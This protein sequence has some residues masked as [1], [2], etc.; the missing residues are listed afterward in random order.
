MHDIPYSALVNFDTGVIADAE[1]IT[2]RRLSDMPGYYRDRAAVER[3][4][5]DDPLLYRVYLTP[6][7][8][9]DARWNVGVSV[10]EPGRVGDEYFMTKGH[11]HLDEAAPEVYTTLSGAGQ[12]LLQTRG[13]EAKT[14]A[15]TPGAV[16][17]IPGEW[18]HRTVNTGDEPLVFLAVWPSD[19]GYDYGTIAERGFA[20]LVLA[21]DD[22]PQIVA[23]PGYE[24]ER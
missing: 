18:A 14:L 17:Y 16:N 22:G 5:A 19:A 20:Q 24:P 12:L 6:G 23:N 10:I 13:G 4:L 7:S 15:M 9:A 8:G 3:L 1:Q 11:Y 21:G 2:E